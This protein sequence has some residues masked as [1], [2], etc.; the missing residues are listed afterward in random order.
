VV[1]YSVVLLK[2]SGCGKMVSNVGLN[3]KFQA[4]NY[5]QIPNNNFQNFLGFW[6]LRFVCNLLFVIWSLR[7]LKILKDPGK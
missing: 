5:K 6:S 1:K 3:P 2:N 4:P 7:L